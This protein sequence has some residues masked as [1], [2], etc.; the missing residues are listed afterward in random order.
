MKKGD[1]KTENIKKVSIAYYIVILFI[2]YDK[3][4]D[5][6]LFRLVVNAGFMFFWSIFVGGVIAIIAFP[7]GGMFISVS[8]KTSDFII[9]HSFS[10]VILLGFIAIL[11]S[12][13]N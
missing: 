5:A 4:P 1:I 6:S 13:Y 9:N 10:I 7:I 2:I 8:K 12:L 11:L 3:E